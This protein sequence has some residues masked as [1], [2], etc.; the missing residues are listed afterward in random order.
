MS[1]IRVA[2]IGL[3]SSAKTTWAADA[4]LAYLLSSKGKTHYQLVALLNSS[5]SAAESAKK[6]FNL[7]Q[8]VKAFGDAETLA[9][10]AD[11]DLVV[12]CTRVDVH[13]AVVEPSVR[14]G[15]A[16]FVE[17]PV[18]SNLASTLQLLEKMPN[19]GN[20]IVGLQGRVMPLTLRL[21]GILSSGIIGKVLSSDIRAYGVVMQRD[22]LPAS[23]AYFADRKVGGHP[24]NIHYG[25][26]IDYVHEVLGNWE[27][28][29]AKM[30]I[31]RPELNIL[32]KEG[33]VL[34]SNVPD[35]LSVHGTLEAGVAVPGALLTATFRLGP[36]FKGD[37]GLT[38]TIAGEKGELRITAPGPYLMSGDSYN[39]PVTIEHHDH[40]T[41]Q[42]NSLAWDWSEWQKE[43]PLRARSTAELYER[44]AEWVEGGKDEVVRGR[45]WPRFEDGVRLMREFDAVYKLFDAMW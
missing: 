42:V 34:K 32:G 18:T 28:F 19:P 38:W 30:Q 2:I 26:M 41:D 23:L 21:Q 39:G 1:P 5:I 11:I 25:H 24:I 17:W 44:Y 15:K 22:T 3:S 27:T 16:V 10:D 36:P 43:L 9:A 6:T 7:P 33:A 29:D 4:H 14:A 37:A 31:Q 13:Y 35:L 20:S 45:E 8:H 12:V 40:A